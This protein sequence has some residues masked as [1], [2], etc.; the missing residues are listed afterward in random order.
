LKY[1]YEN[2]YFH[3]NKGAL[4]AIISPETNKVEKLNTKSWSIYSTIL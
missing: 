3:V 2:V 4:K 1:L